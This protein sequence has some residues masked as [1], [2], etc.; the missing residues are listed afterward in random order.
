MFRS[1]TA[2]TLVGTTLCAALPASAINRRSC[3]RGISD[4]LVTRSERR[5][6]KNDVELISILQSLR[7][8][9]SSIFGTLGVS[10]KP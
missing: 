9:C 5:D 10:M 2:I 7:R 4:L 1:V 6:R 3:Q 8:Q